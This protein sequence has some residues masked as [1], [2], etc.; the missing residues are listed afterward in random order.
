MTAT[1]TARRSTAETRAA[2][3]SNKKFRQHLSTASDARAVRTREALRA[4]LLS[5]LE[6]KPLDAIGIREIAAA[7]GIGHATF[8]R[9]HPTKEA[10][11]HDLAADEVQSLVNLTAPL[12]DAEGSQ[13]ACEALFAYA[14]EHRALWSTFLNGGAAGA[15]RAEMLRLSLDLAAAQLP[16]QARAIGELCVRLMVGG[17]IEMLTWWLKDPNPPPVKEVAKALS[18]GVVLPVLARVAIF[19]DVPPG[20]QRNARGARPSRRM[21]VAP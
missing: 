1:R 9:H 7:A 19:M 12:M 3:R 17:T 6:H 16:V 15:V 4:A 13:A 20:V 14:H 8:Y 2:P 18:Q 21:R 10:L 5:L 11:L